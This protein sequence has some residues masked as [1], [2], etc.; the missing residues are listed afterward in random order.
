MADEATVAGDL[1]R[2]PVEIPAVMMA[3]DGAWFVDEDPA[4]VEH[5]E[6]RVQVAS[7][8]SRSPDVECRIESA[9]PFQ[10]RSPERHVRARAEVAGPEEA[11][12]PV[13]CIGEVPVNPT[14]GR[15]APEPALVLEQLLSGRC[16]LE[17]H[18]EPR[19]G[20]DVLVHRKGFAQGQ[21]PAG[22]HY[23]VVVGECDDLACRGC[24]PPIARSVESRHRL[25]DIRDTVEGLDN[26][27]RCPGGGGVV[28]DDDLG[29]PVG[30]DHSGE[31]RSE[32]VGPVT[33]ADNHRCCEGGVARD[34]IWM[35]HHPESGG[36]PAAR[37]GRRFD[38]RPNPSRDEPVE[39]LRANGQD[40]IARSH[41]SVDDR[42]LD[43][44]ENV[45]AVPDQEPGSR[46]A[47]RDSHRR[48]WIGQIEFPDGDRRHRE[49][50]AAPYAL[51]HLAHRSRLLSRPLRH[52]LHPLRF[53]DLAR[54]LSARRGQVMRPT[55]WSR[56]PSDSPRGGQR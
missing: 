3:D 44:T 48:L 29:H 21:D 35:R 15:P 53:C 16:Q 32:L 54:L 14:P 27:T 51:V 9:D 37:R 12:P 39:Q 45:W 20:P 4:V 40:D 17:W 34:S 23:G 46:L 31:C 55:R 2:E 24:Q 43:F 6:H 52:G 18:D 36:F 38:D 26:V 30:I 33:G 1:L 10:L 11:A 8:S 47:A 50:I 56:T 49:L 7:A 5:L 22:I 13:R 19:H 25:D 41:V 28:D 42:H